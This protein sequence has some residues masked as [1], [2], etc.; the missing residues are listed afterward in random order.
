MSS[1][2]GCL[3]CGS[4]EERKRRRVPTVGCVNLITLL[5]CR[6]REPPHDCTVDRM[7]SFTTGDGCD[8]GIARLG[9]EIEELKNRKVVHAA[10]LIGRG[11]RRVCGWLRQ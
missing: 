5:L 3:R 6:T 2:L 8:A 7:T 4:P 9:A 11:G 10:N 1:P